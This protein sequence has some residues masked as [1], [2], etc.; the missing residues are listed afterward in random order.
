MINLQAPGRL[1]KAPAADRILEKPLGPAKMRATSSGV[2]CSWSGFTCAPDWLKV[3]KTLQAHHVLLH[4]ASP[5]GYVG[6]AQI[7]DSFDLEAL[8]R[9][10]RFSQKPPEGMQTRRRHLGAL[11]GGCVGRVLT[12][13]GSPR[14]A[15][16]RLP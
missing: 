4:G 5:G 8:V 3:L 12:Q 13:G 14:A 11:L 2:D 16:R 1:G 7:R 9:S 15:A 10:S 6:K